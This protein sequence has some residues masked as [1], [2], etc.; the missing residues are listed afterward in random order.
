MPPFVVLM[1][2]DD[3]PTLSLLAAIARHEGFDALLADDGEK[4]MAILRRQAVDA[5]VLDLILPVTSG[6]EVL[7]HCK[8]MMPALLDRTIVITAAPEKSWRNCEEIRQVRRFYRKPLDFIDLTSALH[9]CRAAKEKEWASADGG[10]GT[11]SVL[12]T[13]GRGNR[14]AS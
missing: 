7:R 9:A 10:Q 1:V 2:E 13:A 8:R 12:A 5:M 11:P 4:A 14:G 6:F 3:R